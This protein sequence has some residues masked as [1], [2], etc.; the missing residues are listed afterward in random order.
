MAFVARSPHPSFERTCPGKPGLIAQLQRSAEEGVCGKS[1]HVETS[2]PPHLSRLRFFGS[3]FP[4][5]EPGMK[6]DRRKWNIAATVGAVLSSVVMIAYLAQPGFLV[7]TA[8]GQP[9]TIIETS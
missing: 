7:Q 8:P 5:K 2:L 3:I 9:P 6:T 1:G 4:R